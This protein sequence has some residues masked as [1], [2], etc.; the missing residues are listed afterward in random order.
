MKAV[1]IDAFGS[2]E[3]AL[4]V[5][6]DEPVPTP[7]PGEIL[8]KVEATSVNPID[9]A[10]REGYGAEFFLSAGLIRL[11]LIPGRDVAG[12]VEAVGPEKFCR[13]SPVTC[14]GEV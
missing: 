8:V 12:T 13:T 4:R 7:A 5:V 10:V 14:V 3:G 9:C 2:A 1:R 11:P 6:M